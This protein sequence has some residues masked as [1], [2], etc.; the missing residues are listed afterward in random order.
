MGFKIEDS[1]GRGH[2]L[3]ITPSN[4]A[5]VS[6]RANFR[7]YYVS[8]DN[9]LAFTWVS[10]F[11]PSSGVFCL[12]IKNDNTIRDLFLHDILVGSDVNQVITVYSITGTAVGTPITPVNLNRKSG[13][14][15]EATS[16]GNSEVVG[17]TAD[18][19]ITI[20]RVQANDSKDVL[21]DDTLILG[22]DDSIAIQCSASGVVEIDVRG[23]YEAGSDD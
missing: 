3:R 7:S 17:L 21:L 10:Q 14:T 20:F 13:N 11:I 23:Y 4:R 16:I 19:K 22:K 15:A 1:T 5:D 6:A 8:R 12:Y 18:E 9:G 2:G